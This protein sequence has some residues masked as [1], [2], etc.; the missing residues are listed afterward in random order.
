MPLESTLRRDAKCLGW[1]TSAA[2]LVLSVLTVVSSGCAGGRRGS[3]TDLVVFVVVDTLR[4][5]HLGVFGYNRD[6]SPFLDS[7][8]EESLF[9]SNMVVHS[10]HTAPSVASLVTSNL[11]SVHGIQFYSQ[12]RDFGTASAAP[13]LND[14]L[15]TMAET[16][17]KAG[18]RT[19]GLVANPWLKSEFGFAQGFDQY[20]FDSCQRDEATVCDGRDL[21][22]KAERLVPSVRDGQKTFLYLH[23]MDVHNPY[24]PFDHVPPFFRQ[25]RGRYRFQN[26]LMPRLGAADLKFTEALYDEK[27]RYVDGLLA[28]FM[29]VLQRNSLADRAVLVVTS[30]HGEEFYDHGGMGHGRT[31]YN[32]V[33]NGF[34][35]LWGPGVF[36]RHEIDSYVPAVDLLPTLLEAVRIPLSPSFKGRSLSST[37]D[38]DTSVQKEA[39]LSEL[40]DQKAVILG[41]LKLIVNLT[42]GEEVFY[43]IGVDGRIELRPTWP[44]RDLQDEMRQIIARA[45]EAADQ[46]DTDLRPVDPD[47]LR[48][49]RSLGYLR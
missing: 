35:I 21:I 20:V 19:V 43:E 48:R 32:E 41:N 1:A 25:D 13:V 26:R 28:E 11:P 39:I 3:T 45:I 47:T 6:T 44:S 22:E 10:S 5:D 15:E 37:G 16:F 17:R 31:L 9:L 40:G 46:T 23:L 38:G 4:R 30:D 42:T 12:T 34:A 18:Y 2:L 33:T 24:G 49:L 8:A 14:G 7:L 36:D 29:G 27:I